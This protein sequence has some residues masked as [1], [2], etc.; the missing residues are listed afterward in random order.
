MKK[1]R[2]EIQITPQEGGAMI[3]D[4]TRGAYFQVNE[5]G[6]MIIQGIATGKTMEELIEEIAEI[7]SLEYDQAKSDVESYFD[8]LRKAGYA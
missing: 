8:S 4:K 5:V 6:L 1:K 3:F 7:Y 2:I